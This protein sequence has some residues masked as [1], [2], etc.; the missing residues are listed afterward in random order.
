MKKTVNLP[1]A[2]K[3]IIVDALNVYQ[4]TVRSLI[5][6]KEDLYLIYKDFDMTC[7][8]GMFKDTD[9]DIRV[10]LPEQLHDGF[11]HKHGVDFPVYSTEGVSFKEN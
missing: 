10:E 11:V 9:I 4:T 6:Q 2:Q 1:Q 3:Q 8:I 7:L 5:S